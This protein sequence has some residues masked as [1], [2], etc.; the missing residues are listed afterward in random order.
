MKLARP[1]WYPNVA[2]PTITNVNSHSSPAASTRW[3]EVQSRGYCLMGVCIWYTYY[4]DSG[5][6]LIGAVRW[7][8]MPFSLWQG[9]V[10][11]HFM[12]PLKR[13]LSL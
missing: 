11:F 6:R 12:F 8:E 7:R 10:F 9:D 13:R 3:A 5:H 4:L 2:P 1:A